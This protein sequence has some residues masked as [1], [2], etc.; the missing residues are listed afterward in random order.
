MIVSPR[1]TASVGVAIVALTA[2]AFVPTGTSP[3]LV[4][5]I[6]PMTVG[7]LPDPLPPGAFVVAQADGS[8]GGS[9][10]RVVAGL[11]VVEPLSGTIDLS[12]GVPGILTSVLV[13]EGQTVTKGQLLASLFNDDLKSKV[14]QAEATLRIKS[15]Q[16]DLVVNGARE[17]EIR[18]AEARLRREESALQLAT[19]QYERRRALVKAGAVS[20]EDFNQASNAFNAAKE[21]L[22]T[23]EDA[24]AILLDGARPEAIETARAEVSLAESQ[25]A[26]ARA[27]LALSEIRATVDGTVLRR[28]R[29]PGEVIGTQAE[30]PVLQIADTSRLVV[31][32]QIDETD[33][34]GLAVGQK[35]MIS[36]PA[37][38]GET[39]TGTV[40]RISP[41]LGAKTLT[42]DDPAEKRDTRVLDVIVGL[43]PD[44]TLPINLRVDVQIDLTMP[45]AAPQPA[46]GQGQGPA[47]V[48]DV[49]LVAGLMS[50]IGEVF[51]AVLR[52][53]EAG[54][55]PAEAPPADVA[56]AATEPSALDIPALGAMDLGLRPAFAADDAPA[57]AVAP[58]PAVTTTEAATPPVGDR[59]VLDAIGPVALADPVSYLPAYGLPSR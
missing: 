1:A 59:L 7:T 38:A 26:E 18:Q 13:D 30:T 6:D 35:A 58:R 37:L 33:I 32:T 15:A 57:A 11:G 42:A 54:P 16:R 45:T 29:E 39:Y 53:A 46:E 25:L 40:T 24:L 20:R 56:A 14:A 23:A 43:E 49:P 48:E 47:P 9:A 41:R 4:A 31:R 19:V 21:A 50:S 44:V 8:G 10:V 55:V 51:D 22:A 27:A 17:E 5:T 36:A 3:P 52:P 12:P 2:L 28:Y 34:A